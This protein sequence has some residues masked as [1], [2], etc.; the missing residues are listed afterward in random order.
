MLL[1]VHS[2]QRH[3]ITIICST[4]PKRTILGEVEHEN[5]VNNNFIII[6]IFNSE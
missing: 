1:Q 6:I 5:N 3:L 2:I 4:G